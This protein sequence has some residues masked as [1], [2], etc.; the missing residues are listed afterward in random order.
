M[1]CESSDENR[2]LILSSNKLEINNAVEFVKDDSAGAISS[3]I[4]TTRNNFDEKIVTYLEYEAYPDMALSELNSIVNEIKTKWDIKKIYI[5]HKLG[6]CPV[7]EKS[8]VIFVSSEH[9]NEAIKSVEFAIENLKSRVP[10]W[11]KV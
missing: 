1:S 7:G 4:G 5:E 6:V 8:V 10:I 11:K 2:K 9:R 3:F